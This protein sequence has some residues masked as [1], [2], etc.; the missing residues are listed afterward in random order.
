[1]DIFAFVKARRRFQNGVGRSDAFYNSVNVYCQAASEQFIEY[2]NQCNDTYAH[3]LGH[4]YK[5]SN[6]HVDQIVSTSNHEGSEP[7]IM[8]HDVCPLLDA[9]ISPCNS[10]NTTVE[11]DIIED[12]ESCI[13]QIRKS[14]KGL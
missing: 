8:T 13:S 3:E 14:G 4:Q 12:S 7:C 1:M 10:I 6:S 5:V 2:Q 11:F 9:D